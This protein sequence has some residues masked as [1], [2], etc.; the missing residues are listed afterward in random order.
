MD[1]CVNDHQKIR[2][3][4]ASSAEE[5]RRLSKHDLRDTYINCAIIAMLYTHS[6]GNQPYN[7]MVVFKMRDSIPSQ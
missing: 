1:L 2:Y 4:R 5:E 6:I 3:Y 7:P